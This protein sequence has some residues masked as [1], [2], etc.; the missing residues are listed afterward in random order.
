LD[1]TDCQGDW[2]GKVFERLPEKML[3]PVLIPCYNERNT[4]ERIVPLRSLFYWLRN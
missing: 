2:H 3:V 1:N 4:I